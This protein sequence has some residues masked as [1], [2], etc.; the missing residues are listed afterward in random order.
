[1]ITLGEAASLMA[2][3]RSTVTAWVRTGRCIGIPGRTMA[4]PRWQFDP[5]V[6]PAIQLV[7]NGLGTTDGWRVLIFMETAAPTLNGLTPRIALEQGVPISRI[8][9]VA[10]A[11]AH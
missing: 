9:D 1:M 2:V 11:D 8:V 3:D 4:L 10:V 5:A 7:V 6:W